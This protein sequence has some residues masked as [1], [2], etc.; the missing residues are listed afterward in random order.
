MQ[1]IAAFFEGEK[2][3]KVNK[4]GEIAKGSHVDLQRAKNKLNTFL[5]QEHGV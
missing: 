4:I 1:L 2:S 3:M 5:L